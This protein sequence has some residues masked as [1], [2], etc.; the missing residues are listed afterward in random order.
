MD[1]SDWPR[2]LSPV[3]SRSNSANRNLRVR[4][5]ST[6]SAPPQPTGSLGTLDAAAAGPP[7]SPPPLTKTA[8]VCAGPGDVSRIDE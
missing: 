4:R 5:I 6:A 1:F 3:T 2:R 8:R 7:G